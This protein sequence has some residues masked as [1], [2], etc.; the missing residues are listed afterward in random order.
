[1]QADSATEAGSSSERSS[2]SMHCVLGDVRRRSSSRNRAGFNSAAKDT[3]ASNSSSAAGK[4]R[5]TAAASP[6]TSLPPRRTRFASG[7]PRQR[8]EAAA[9]PPR[10][11]PLAAMCGWLHGN[12]AQSPTLPTHSAYSADANVSYSDGPALPTALVPLVALSGAFFGGS[13]LGFEATPATA[14]SPASRSM[15]LGGGGV[16]GLDVPPSGATADASTAAAPGTAGAP[17]PHIEL[18]LG[19]GNSSAA[20]AALHEVSAVPQPHDSPPGTAEPATP[21]AQLAAASGNHATGSGGVTKKSRS[22]FK[23]TP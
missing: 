17:Q 12:K 11:N 18:Y 9:K 10:R 1:M 14:R 6:A 7:T 22:G 16:S 23:T 3:A 2:R 20:A 15:A 4:H 21:A 19:G 13:G 5:S 8:K